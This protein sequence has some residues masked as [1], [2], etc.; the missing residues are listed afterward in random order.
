METRLVAATTQTQT[1]QP[2]NEFRPNGSKKHNDL[3]S[4]NYRTT[5]LAA[6]TTTHPAV[7]TTQFPHPQ[8]TPQKQKT[9]T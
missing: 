7:S 3:F 2:L 6:T 4:A 5:V 1:T 8:T 9:R